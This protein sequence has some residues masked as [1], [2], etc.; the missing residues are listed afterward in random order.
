MHD[1]QRKSIATDKPFR[2]TGSNAPMPLFGQDQALGCG[3]RHQL[4][5]DAVF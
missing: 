3:I 5:S 1:Q 2:I 4:G